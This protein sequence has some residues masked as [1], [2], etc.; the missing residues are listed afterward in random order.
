[1]KDSSKRL[2]KIIYTIQSVDIGKFDTNLIIYSFGQVEG[3]KKAK[4]I[5]DLKNYNYYT[6]QR[7]NYINV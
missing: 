7:W 2:E 4:E 1:M 3:N 5:C 6:L